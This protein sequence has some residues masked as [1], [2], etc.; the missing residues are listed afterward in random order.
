M[1]AEAE[2]QALLQ[3][4]ADHRALGDQLSDLQ[5]Q[6]R[7]QLPG[8]EAQL[9]Q[10]SAAIGALRDQLAAMEEQL[11]DAEAGHQALL[12]NLAGHRALGDEFLDLQARSCWLS[13]AS[14]CRS[15]PPSAPS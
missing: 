4:L 11:V 12:Q 2:R 7:A 15:W 1:D 8:V 13:R 14:C 3:S 6:H 10:V 9:L 5:A